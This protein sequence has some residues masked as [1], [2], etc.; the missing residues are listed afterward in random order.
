M[1]WRRRF[2]TRNNFLSTTS[3]A[4]ISGSTSIA[5]LSKEKPLRWTET[6]THT[7]AHTH[8]RAEKSPFEKQIPKLDLSLR[9][10]E[11][12]LSKRFSHPDKIHGRSHMRK[13]AGTGQGR[14]N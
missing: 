11:I 13:V 4:C 5:L 2:L 12:N 6:H 9:L 14:N 10:I 1:T 3:L 7:H 8:M